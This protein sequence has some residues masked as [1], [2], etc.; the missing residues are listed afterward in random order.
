[1]KEQPE[2]LVKMLF[3]VFKANR[4]SKPKKALD[5]L[6]SDFTKLGRVSEV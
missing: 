3:I 1:M 4:E 5:S 6:P 2:K